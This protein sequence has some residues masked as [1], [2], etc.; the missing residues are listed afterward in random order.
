MDIN[1]VGFIIA[2]LVALYCIRWLILQVRNNNKRRF[3][4]KSVS[5]ELRCLECNKKHD[6]SKSLLNEPKDAEI[7]CDCG[8]KMIIRG[9]D[10]A[11]F[12]DFARRMR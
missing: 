9:E 4:Q 12:M 8:N 2:A 1:T 3:I 10:I 7:V 5:M 6:I 11:D